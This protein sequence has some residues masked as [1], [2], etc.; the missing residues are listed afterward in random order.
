MPDLFESSERRSIRDLGPAERVRGAFAI[1]NAQLGKTRQDKP[2]LRCLLR[3]RT[4]E[5]SGRMWSIDE[6]TFQTLPTD[7]FVWLEGETQPYQGQMQLIIHKIEPIEPTDEQMRDLLPSS[8]RDPEEMFKEVVALLD[9]LEHPAMKA[10]ATVYLEDEF[11]MDQFRRAPAAKAMHHAFLGGL[12]EHTL[13]LMNLASAVCAFY[14]KINRDLVLMGLFL[15]DL[16]KT[17]ELVYDRGFGYSDRG[18]LIGHIV[19]GAIMLHDKS[20]QMMRATGQ[21]LPGHALTVLQHIILS[22]HTLPE[23]GAAKIPSTPEAIL[24]AM[25]DNLDAKTTIALDAT[26]GES[27]AFDLGGNFTD[28]LWALDTKLFRPDPLAPAKAPEVEG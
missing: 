25:L 5:V 19:E 23:H 8:K 24:V 15:H 16:G 21:R 10:L 26:R 13:Q 27:P 17:R 3:D 9:T 12:L 14:P 2:Y 20:Q 28:R 7:G 22:H 11:L 1:S 6:A 4:G 18:E